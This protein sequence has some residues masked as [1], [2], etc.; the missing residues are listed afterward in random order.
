V[1]SV[2]AH[3]VVA[4]PPDVVFAYAADPANPPRYVEGLSTWEHCGGPERGLGSQFRAGL[5]V[6]PKEL[7]STV[8]ITTYDEGA[9][10]GW[11]PVKGFGQSGHWTM[12][13]DGEGTA[14]DFTVSYEMPGGMLGR[15]IGGMLG[16]V[17]QHTVDASV[18]NLKEQ[19][20]QNAQAG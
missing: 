16:G 5:H 10:L 18:R 15:L 7:V 2:T 6:G 1:P 9:A 17:V 8:E 11:N 13:P 19:V 20:E 3:A 14:I 4:A 12:T